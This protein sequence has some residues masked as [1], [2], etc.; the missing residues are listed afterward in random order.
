[1]A[2]A[3]WLSWLFTMPYAL[4]LPSFVILELPFGWY[5][6]DLPM[7]PCFI[8]SHPSHCASFISLTSSSRHPSSDL[9]LDS[10][11]L[12]LLSIDAAGT[13]ATLTVNGTS[14]LRGS[15]NSLWYRP[16]CRRCDHWW[17]GS[18]IRHS[19]VGG[20]CVY[21]FP[22]GVTRLEFPSQVRHRLWLGERLEEDARWSFLLLSNMYAHIGFWPMRSHLSRA[23]T[24]ALS[25]I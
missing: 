18:H 15:P 10:F 25:F 16:C 5:R 19:N 23:W 1:M 6:Y 14:C 24:W 17:A 13:H 22:R 11:R 9:N 20:Q 3:R 8:P 7:T 4:I 12:P 21:I 2:Y